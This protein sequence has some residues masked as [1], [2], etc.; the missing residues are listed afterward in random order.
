LLKVTEIRR[1]YAVAEFE[2]GHAYQQVSQ[3][4][5]YTASLILAVELAGAKG[6]GRDYRVNGHRDQQLFDEFLSL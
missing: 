5:L 4:D 6:Q 3:R 1:G 2:C